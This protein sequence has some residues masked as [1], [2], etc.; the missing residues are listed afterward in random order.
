[1]GHRA[2]DLRAGPRPGRPARDAAGPGAQDPGRRDADQA[3]A[4]GPGGGRQAAGQDPLPARRLH[5]PGHPRGDPGPGHDPDRERVLMARRPRERREEGAALVEMAIVIGI[6][7]MFL[8]GIITFGVTL[9]FQQ[10][11]TQAGNE[12]A[13]AA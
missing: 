8:F 3:A 10:T 7:A 5:L 6:L 11:L 9:S 2:V 12:A 13:R 1:P 4:V